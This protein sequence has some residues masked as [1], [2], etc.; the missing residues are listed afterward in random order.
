MPSWLGRRL[1]RSG[2]ALSSY[3]QLTLQGKQK[4]ANVI[5]ASAGAKVDRHGHPNA[6][7]DKRKRFMG[8]PP[9]AFSALPPKADFPILKL[10]PPPT[11]RERRHRGLARRPIAVG[12]HAVLVILEG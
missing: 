3:L 2:A 7:R 11:L 4:I 1:R 9:H 12:R 8:P 6:F 10:L 5:A